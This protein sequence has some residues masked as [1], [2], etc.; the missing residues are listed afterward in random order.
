MTYSDFH[1]HTNFCDGRDGPEEMVLAA[2]E[3]GMPRLGFSGHSYTSFDGRYC[4]SREG[5][6]AYRLEVARLREKYAGRIEIFCGVEQDLFSDAPVEGYDYVIGSVHYLYAGGRYLSA[7]VSEAGLREAIDECFGG[8]PYAMAELYYR[9]AAGL[10]ARTGADIIGHFDLVTK[11]NEGGAIFDE[12]CPRYTAAA[13]AA[14]D[15]LLETGVPFEI[16]TG[17]IFRGFRTSPYPSPRLLR[18][19]AERGGR[20]V[21]SSD[22]HRSDALCFQFDECRELAA[23]LGATVLE[24]GPPPAG[25]IL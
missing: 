19:I 20:V 7:D 1:V 5:T 21:L 2:L 25:A 18:R 15:A 17:A 8:D 4:M 3:L 9:Q 10:V 6:E 11:F 14:L 16:N 23:S 13:E 22:S 24:F 12:D